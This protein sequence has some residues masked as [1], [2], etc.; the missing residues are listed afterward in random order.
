MQLHVFLVP[1]LSLCCFCHPALQSPGEAAVAAAAAQAAAPGGTLPPP[2]RAPPPV[3]R[4]H[5]L[6]P[7][8]AWQPPLAATEA[9]GGSDRPLSR[10]AA[11]APAAV[12]TA[13]SGAGG[14][15][16][17]VDM[18]DR[19]PGRERPPQ[20]QLY[21]TA[22]EDQGAAD[23]EDGA[24]GF[25]VRR[26]HGEGTGGAAGPH[27][28]AEASVTPTRRHGLSPRRQPPLQPRQP[29]PLGGPHVALGRSQ[30]QVG[31]MGCALGRWR[32]RGAEL[33]RNGG[34]HGVWRDMPCM[35]SQRMRHFCELGSGD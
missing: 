34:S 13:A 9:A 21:R 3:P 26:G 35:V 4:F 16:G 27:V 10:G 23:G 24:G 14:W 25:F 2:R 7:Q 5:D 33:V 8:S 19:M 11:R 18:P 32:P 20:Q 17:G 28:E 22:L 1:T 29:P 30:Q 6:P 12:G 15:V 31:Q